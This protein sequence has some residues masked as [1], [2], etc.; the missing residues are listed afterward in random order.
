MDSFWKQYKQLTPKVRYILHEVPEARDSDF[1]L[2]SEIWHR[3]IERQDLNYKEVLKLM[4]DGKLAKPESITRARRKLQE[5]YPK[6]RGKNW[7][8][9]HKHERFVRSVI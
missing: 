5:Y 2:I 1:L 6:L 3:D 9:R 7:L 8:K 4:I